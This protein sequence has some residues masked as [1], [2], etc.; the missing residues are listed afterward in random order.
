MHPK[1]VVARLK[2]LREDANTL[3]GKHHYGCANTRNRGTCD[4]RLTIRRDVLEETL[5]SGLRDRVVIEAWRHHYNT[6]R[7]HSVLG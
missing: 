3:V 1:A 7:P 6:V 5:L 4:N 2:L